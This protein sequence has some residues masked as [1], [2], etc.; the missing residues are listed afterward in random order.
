[1]QES[2]KNYH[3]VVKKLK[4]LHKYC[5]ASIR[6]TVSTKFLLDTKL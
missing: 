3:F 4:L 1:M 5:S 2:L 6:T